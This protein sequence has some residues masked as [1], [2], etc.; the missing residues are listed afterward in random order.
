MPELREI[1]ALAGG[2][3]QPAAFTRGRMV[4]YL[5]KSFAS[6]GGVLSVDMGASSLTMTAAFGDELFLN[7]FPQFGL[8]ESLA[9]LMRHTSLE[10]LARWLPLSLPA[11]ALRNYLYQKSIYPAALPLT[12]EELALEHT[13][14]RH[15]LQLAARTFF[16][17][18]PASLRSPGASQPSF[19]LILASG[20]ALTNTPALGQRLMIL[21]DSLQPVGV[22]TLLVDQS[23]LLSMLGGVAEQNS[24]LP[25]HV[26]HSGALSYLATVISPASNQP[27]GTPIVQAKL[28]RSDGGVSE[29]EVKMGGLHILPLESGQNAQ[30]ELRPLQKADVGLGPGNAGRVNVLGSAIGVVIDARG[31]PIRL[32]NEPEKRLDLL[33]RWRTR[34]EASI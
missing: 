4:R 8:G 13:L 6:E 14:M 33:Q 21:L 15:L 10:E 5:A 20:S 2:F 31:R 30:L 11:D 24:L 12:P 1:R 9:G 19:E 27:Y 22:T 32:P 23:N 28:L 29:T 25:V 3:L 16:S 17:R 34:M 18:L 26:A 7:V